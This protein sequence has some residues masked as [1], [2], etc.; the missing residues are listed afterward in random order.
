MQIHIG[1]KQF[2]IGENLPEN[3]RT[4]LTAAV[5]RHFDRDAEAH[6]TFAKERTGFRNGHLT[7]GTMLQARGSGL[8]AYK[9]FDAALDRLE[10]QVRRYTRRHKNHHDRDAGSTRFAP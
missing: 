10:N 9:S 5:S 3:V 8:D 2:D 6:V 1:A 4:E 7:L